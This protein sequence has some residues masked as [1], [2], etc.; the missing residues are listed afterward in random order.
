MA[1]QKRE[2]GRFRAAGGKVTQFPW[3]Q[4]KIHSRKHMTRGKEQ[5]TQENSPKRR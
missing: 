2:W 4:E 1:E 3:M 5:Q